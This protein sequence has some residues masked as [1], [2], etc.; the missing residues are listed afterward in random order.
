MQKRQRFHDSRCEMVLAAAM[1]LDAG[2]QLELLAAMASLFDRSAADP[3]GDGD[4]VRLAAHALRDVAD[5]LGRSPSIALYEEVRQTLPELRLPP[6][7]TIRRWLGGS[8]NDC[9]RRTFL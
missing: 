7:G 6:N 8:W 3:R 9:L 2:E 1:V 4:R 5:V